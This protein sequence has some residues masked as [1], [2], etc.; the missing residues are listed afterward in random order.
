MNEFD[1]IIGYESEKEELARLC[2]TLK[3]RA[4]YAKLGMNM[5]QTL[6][7]YGPPGVGKTLMAKAFIAESKRKSFLLQKG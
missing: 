6:L 1:K 3:N 2:D 5:P 4:K 7:L